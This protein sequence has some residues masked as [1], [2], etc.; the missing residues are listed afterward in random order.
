MALAGLGAVFTLTFFSVK[1]QVRSADDY[2][3]TIDNVRLLQELNARLDRAAIEAE[4]GVLLNYDALNVT[5]RQ[6]S[7]VQGRL[8]DSASVLG[9]EEIRAHVAASGKRLHEKDA[10]IEVFESRN[11]IFRNSLVYLPVAAQS[12]ASATGAS[13]FGARVGDEL[14]ALLANVMCRSECDEAALARLRISTAALAETS[15]LLSPEEQRSLDPLL[16]HAAVFAEYSPKVDAAI[17]AVLAADGRPYEDLFVA[18]EENHEHAAARVGVYRML[19]VLLSIGLASAVAWMILRLRKNAKA[20]GEAMTDLAHKK[21]I[22]EEKRVELAQLNQSLETRVLERTQEVTRGHEQYRLLLDTSRAIPWEMEPGSIALS[23]VGAQARA[24]LGF[25]L[26]EWTRPGFLKERLRPEDRER[27]IAR[28]FAEGE[29]DEIEFATTAMDG[30][31]H[32]FRCYVTKSMGSDGLVTRRGLLFDISTQRMLE[33]ELRAAQKLEGI[34][35]L[36]SGIAHEINTPVQFV[37]DNVA[38]FAESFQKVS[39]LLEK[40][41][42]ATAANPEMRAAEEAAD[43]EFILANAPDALKS[44]VDGLERI[45]TIV[46]SMKEFSHPDR[47]QKVRVD[48]NANIQSTLTIARNEY[49]HVADVSTDFGA[50]P[51]VLCHPGE[52]NQVILNLIVNA[53][54]AIGDVS[55]SSGKLG[56]ITVRTVREGTN[57]HIT[58]GDTGAGI[59][60]ENRDRLFEP[61]FTTKQVGQ[62]TGQGLAI[63]R[64]I[65]HDKHHGQISFES[66]VGVGT[67]FSIRLPLDAE[68]V[69]E[70]RAA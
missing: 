50:L 7:R 26:A 32:W 63:S 69:A 18:I 38:F 57:A 40:Y 43:L 1:S 47:K 17:D 6:M 44:S 60:P 70:V 4:V 15:A 35:R 30:Q 14:T 66:E 12:A 28:F 9:D 52:I 51:P 42:D 55:R 34:G 13:P 27:T 5:L 24:A 10:T 54:H 45:A 39:V 20:L 62:G 68:A 58:I 33:G 41:R 31:V 21:E 67:T 48:L 64:S 23:Y 61:F 11:S 8:E 59:A 46:R 37:G 2:L 29:H 22:V 16:R 19:L 25:P 56:K 65:V 53:A 49:R 3:E 36:A